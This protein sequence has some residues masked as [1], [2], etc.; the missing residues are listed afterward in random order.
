M[1]NLQLREFALTLS[2]NGTNSLDFNDLLASDAGRVPAVQ[3]QENEV[4]QVA[5]LCNASGFLGFLVQWLRNLKVITLLR[6]W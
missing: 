1:N 6:S 5:F 4:M 2:N 3:I